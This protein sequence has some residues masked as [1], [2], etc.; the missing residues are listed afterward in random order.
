MFFGDI[1][2]R[3]R[4]RVSYLLDQFLTDHT[5]ARAD[6]WGGDLSQRLE[7]LVATIKT[8]GRR[9]IDEPKILIGDL[10]DAGQQANRTLAFGPDGM[11]HISIGSTCNA[12]SEN[13]PENATPLRATPD[14]PSR[15]I[16]ERAV[17]SV[18]IELRGLRLATQ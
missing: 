11:L 15:A 16:V 3:D 8:V 13:K 1:A 17:S 6:R 7:A 9:D 2:G 12:C 5:N 10:P 18:A 14:A 4:G